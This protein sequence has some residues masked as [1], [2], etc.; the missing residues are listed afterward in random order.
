[1][2]RERERH[3]LPGVPILLFLLAGG[4]GLFANIV[5]LIAER[6][7]PGLVAFGDRSQLRAWVF[8]LAGFFIVNPNEGA[9]AA[10]LR[11]LRRHR[12]QDAG[13]AGSN[14]FYTR[15]QSRC[16]SGTS[17]APHLKVN[18]KDGNPIEIA[19]VVVWQVVDTAEATF[20]VDN[21]ENYVQRAERIGAAQ[22]GDELSL[23][24]ARRAGRDLA[25]RQ[26]RGGRRAPEAGDAAAPA[27]GRRRGDRGAHQPPGL[28][29]GNRGRHAAAPAGRRHHRRAHADRRRRGRHG[30]NGARL[31]VANAA[32]CTSTRSARPRWSATCWSSCAASGRR[33]R[34]S[35]P[36]R[37]T[38]KAP[39]ASWPSESPSS[40]APTP[41]CSTPMQRWAND[42]LRSLNAQVEFV[43]RAA[44]RSSGRLAGP[45]PP[46]PPE[47]ASP[48]DS[49]LPGSGEPG[50]SGASGG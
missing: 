33:S 37:S 11:Q 10:A 42:D 14:P 27:E 12:P 7:H 28:R 38:S 3:G 5:R 47:A 39:G 20:E 41:P 45:P 9:G 18:D 48:E 4:V 26:H 43:L 46:A 36:G 32:S 29:A 8:L 22:R 6:A 13:C 21:Y 50:G 40:C 34:S 17:R 30:G 2:V 1:M 16:A 19:A 25:A 15:K 23:R 49:S 24:L 31:A 44:L 35:T